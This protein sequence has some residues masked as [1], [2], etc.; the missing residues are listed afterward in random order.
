MAAFRMIASIGAMLGA[1][2]VG[3]SVQAADTELTGSKFTCLQ[4]TNG[5]GANSSTKVQSNLARLWMMGY[6]TGYYKGQNKLEMSDE[7]ADEQ[8]MDSR[9]VDACKE[10][11]QNSILS[12][13]SQA[14]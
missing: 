12:V 14:I 6:L 11:Q 9:L 10:N 4:Y 7:K 13:V 5:L 1:L 8:K 2:M 3:A